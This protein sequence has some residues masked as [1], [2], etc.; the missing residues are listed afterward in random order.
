MKNK[1]CSIGRRAD[2][3]S[4]DFQKGKGGYW[5]VKLLAIG[6]GWVAKVYAHF[7]VTF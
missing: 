2:Q 5:D 6:R 1:H 3:R 4:M 7:D